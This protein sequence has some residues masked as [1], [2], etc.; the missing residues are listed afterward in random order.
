MPARVA[1]VRLRRKCSLVSACVWCEHALN[2]NGQWELPLGTG[3]VTGAEMSSQGKRWRNWCVLLCVLDRR[4]FSASR[5]ASDCCSDI[6]KEQRGVGLQSPPTLRFDPAV[7][8]V[9]QALSKS[10]AVIISWKSRTT[11]RERRLVAGA[12]VADGRKQTRCHSGRPLDVS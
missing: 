5:S 3:G 6:Q 11:S 7:H 2:G 12:L 4:G 1:R 8:L 9:R 10:S